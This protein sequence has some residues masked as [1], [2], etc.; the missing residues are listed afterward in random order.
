M[1]NG[2][3]VCASC[4]KLSSYKLIDH[5]VFLN[6]WRDCLS[7]KFLIFL[8]FLALT[9]WYKMAH[10]QDGGFQTKST[11]L[12]QVARDLKTLDTTKAIVVFAT[13]CPAC[14]GEMPA[15]INASYPPNAKLYALSID[16]DRSEFEKY[17]NTF[18]N[19]AVEWVYLGHLCNSKYCQNISGQL[20]AMGVQFRG[21]IPYLAVFDENGHAMTSP[22][23]PYS[24]SMAACLMKRQCSM[25]CSSTMCH[26]KGRK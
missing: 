1:I 10:R 22:T 12:E 7:K 26:F 14:R 25:S 17:K 4:D 9:V 8:I 5:R 3:D 15:F 21:S 18:K 11:S 16:R 13:W 2:Y 23:F 24:P 19:S 6:E 20:S